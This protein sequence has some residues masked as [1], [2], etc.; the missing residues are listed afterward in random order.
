MKRRERTEI[1]VHC[2]EAFLKTWAQF[3]LDQEEF[4]LLEEPA[5]SLV[6]IKM[7]ESAK[8]SL[9]YLGEMLVSET[10]VRCQGHIGIGIVQGNAL[11][12]SYYM[13]VLDAAYKAALP[14]LDQLEKALRKEHERYQERRQKEITNILKT[15]VQF[16]TMDV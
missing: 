9:F 11:D 7:R 5:N 8:N 16:E 15:R 12:V 13:A 4:S 6:M 2:D 1:L 14:G 10:R 3:F